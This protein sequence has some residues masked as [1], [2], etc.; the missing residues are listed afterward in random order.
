MGQVYRFDPA[1]GRCSATEPSAAQVEWLLLLALGPHRTPRR[2]SE[3]PLWDR[4]ATGP[5]RPPINV[6][7]SCQENGWTRSWPGA[8]SYMLGYYSATWAL[9]KAGRAEVDHQR[10]RAAFAIAAALP[11]TPR[12]ARLMAATIE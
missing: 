9:T 11:N 2:P 7:R 6:L 5:G 3:P 1:T 8:P 12:L 4:K 10:A